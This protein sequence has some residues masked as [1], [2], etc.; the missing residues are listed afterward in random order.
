MKWSCEIEAMRSVVGTFD[1]LLHRYGPMPSGRA[2]SGTKTMCNCLKPHKFHRPEVATDVATI[3]CSSSKKNQSTSAPLNDEKPER[4]H[5][6]RSEKSKALAAVRIS[7]AKTGIKNL[8]CDAKEQKIEE[9]LQAAQ[10]VSSSY[11]A[12]NPDGVTA[13]QKSV[14]S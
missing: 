8:C 4:Q 9:A 1:P 2:Q 13:T 10:D 6:S 12:L 7:E 5:T 3:S 11:K 14:K